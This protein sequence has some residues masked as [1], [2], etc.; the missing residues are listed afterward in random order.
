MSD[1]VKKLTVKLKKD[2]SPQEEEEGAVPTAE[3]IV[4]PGINVTRL[5]QIWADD[6]I[7]TGTARKTDAPESE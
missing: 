3:V 6:C 4:F 2:I 1:E 5:W 7:A